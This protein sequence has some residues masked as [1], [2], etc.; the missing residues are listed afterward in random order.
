MPTFPKPARCATQLP[1][2]QPPRQGPR[3]ESLSPEIQRQIERL[4]AGML[5]DHVVGRLDCASAEGSHD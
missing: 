5:R 2:F 3:W 1:L 4:L